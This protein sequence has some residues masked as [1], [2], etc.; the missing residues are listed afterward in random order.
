MMR[1]GVLAIGAV[2]AVSVS[3]PVLGEEGGDEQARKEVRE[4]MK[5][6]QARYEKTKDLHAEDDDRRI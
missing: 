4:V 1:L 3:Y 5:R 6:L 2:L